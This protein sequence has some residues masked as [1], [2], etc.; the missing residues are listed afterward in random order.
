[1]YQTTVD[2]Y[3]ASTTFRYVAFTKTW[4]TAG[5]HTIKV[6]AVGTE[7][8]RRVDVDAFGVIR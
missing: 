8:R 2:L 6:V 7:G 4:A 1:V 3:A 5:E